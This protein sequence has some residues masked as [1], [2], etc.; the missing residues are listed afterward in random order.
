MFEDVS[1]F[2]VIVARGAEGNVALEQK[3]DIVVEDC[4]TRSFGAVDYELFAC[5]SA[6][7]LAKTGVL[8]YNQ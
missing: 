4:I 1:A 6:V 2:G 8:C 7:S 3:S 5:P